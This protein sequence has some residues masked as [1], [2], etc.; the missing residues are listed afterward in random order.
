MFSGDEVTLGCTKSFNIKN[1]GM[2][3]I[4]SV[5]KKTQLD[6][7]CRFDTGVTDG[8]AVLIKDDWQRNA[9]MILCH[10]LSCRGHAGKAITGHGDAA[11]YYSC[12]QNC[13]NADKLL[14]WMVYVAV[15]TILYFWMFVP[16]R[17]WGFGQFPFCSKFFAVCG[18]CCLSQPAKVWR[19][20]IC[21]LPVKINQISNCAADAL[22]NSVTNTTEL[23]LYF[24]SLRYTL[25][26][27]T[28]NI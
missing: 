4:A 12:L 2:S 6:P 13:R 8:I 25:S 5:P 21:P 26:K 15:C 27:T 1:A 23:I 14:M 19:G 11:Q 22:T 16:R 17:L 7:F 18:M 28:H 9:S 3:R 10:G 20:W 24:T